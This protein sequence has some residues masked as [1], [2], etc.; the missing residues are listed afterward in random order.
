MGAVHLSD[1][2]LNPQVHALLAANLVWDNH[3]CMPL[4]PDDE[5]F[6]PQLKRY[7]DSG[8]DLVSINVGFDAVAPDQTLRVAEYFHRWI[9]ERP[10]SYVLVRHVADIDVARTSKRLGVFFDL[11]GGSALEGQLDRVE[12]FYDLGVRW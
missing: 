10:E 9:L 11:E 2:E 12:R 8:V 3:G 1:A 7:H 4:R 6:L 5:T